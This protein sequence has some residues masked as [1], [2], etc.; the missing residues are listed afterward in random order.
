MDAAKA[1]ELYR[2][3]AS[4]GD[5]GGLYNL[6]RC[7]LEGIGIEKDM[8]KAQLWLGLAAKEKGDFWG[9]AAKANEMLGR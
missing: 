9:Y 7:Y 1:F 8:D 5:A 3:S 4:E 2:Q 6:G